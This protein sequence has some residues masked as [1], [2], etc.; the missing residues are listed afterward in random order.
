[1][2]RSIRALAIVMAFVFMVADGGGNCFMSNGVCW[3]DSGINGSMPV[4][5]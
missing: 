4:G 5:E 2:F 1:M 3:V